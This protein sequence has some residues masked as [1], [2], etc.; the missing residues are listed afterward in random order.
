MQSSSLEKQMLDESSVRKSNDYCV[1]KANER[2][3]KIHN[4]ESGCLCVLLLNLRDFD[5][6]AHTSDTR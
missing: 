2:G 5:T 3:K 4:L 1:E 6:N